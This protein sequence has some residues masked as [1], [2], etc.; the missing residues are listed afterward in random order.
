MCNKIKYFCLV[1]SSAVVDAVRPIYIDVHLNQ[2]YKTPA[3]NKGWGIHTIEA[4][5][6][7]TDPQNP[8]RL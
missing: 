3:H 1:K 4:E 6:L 8:T 7:K 5:K 2:S